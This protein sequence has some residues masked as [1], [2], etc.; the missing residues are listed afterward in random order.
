[1]HFKKLI[2]LT[3]SMLMSLTSMAMDQ[4]DLANFHKAESLLLAKN[5]K[6]YYQVK[7][8]LTKVPLYP[9]LQYQEISVDPD[10]FK[11][12]TIDAYLKQNAGSFWAS[13]LKQ[14]LANYY[15][16]QKKW[17]NFLY[18]YDN[19][20]GFNGKCYAVVAEYSVG[21]KG[22]AIN[23]FTHLW[24]S[25]A[26]LP[27][28]CDDF[29]SIWE[30][31]AHLSERQIRLKAYALA[32]SGRVKEAL[33]WIN[34]TSN[35]E[36][37]G[38]YALWLKTTQNPKKY[39]DDW[40][41]KFHQING[42]SSAAISVM[43]N[44]S[45]KDT[46]YAED[47][48][49]NFKQKH[50][51]DNKTINLINAEIAIDYARAHNK[52]AIKWLND[53]EDKYASSLL[54]QWR[55]RTAIYWSDYKSYL[56][57]YSKL[58]QSL[59][60]EEGWR[61]WQAKSYQA[62]KQNDKAKSILTA[63]A[64]NVSYY[65]FLAAD[66]L[67]L[68]YTLNNKSAKVDQKTLDDMASNQIVL[69]I[70]DLYQIKEYGLSYALWRFSR[71]GFTRAE[72]LAIAELAAQQQIYQ[73]S[74]SAYASA[75]GRD[76]LTGLYPLAF[77]SDVQKAGKEF[78]I[79]PEVIIS[80]MRQ[81]SAFRVH[82]VSSASATGLMQLLPTTAAFLA[83]KYRISYENDD[84]YKPNKVIMLGAANL[85]FM[86][87]LF[88]NNLIIGM[89]AYNAG[90]GNAVNWLPAQKLAA[91]QWIEIIPFGETRKYVK[92]ILRNLVIYNQAIL[93]NKKF[94]LQQVMQS[95]SQKDKT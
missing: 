32:S 64:K 45:A 12:E 57:W 7:A 8:K 56:G 51:L 59:K 87:Q 81:E 75:G 40:A 55:L 52:K 62:L 44:L 61:Y 9:F 28:T 20:L 80:M 67:G 36:L 70:F 71:H 38:F 91:D 84:L 65:G 10:L 16:K 85:N 31:S 4:T 76:N 6:D 90:Q 49:L 41:V 18:Y 24:L 54:W 3:S 13:Q 93:G 68:S 15:L 37:Q 29:E 35:K 60:S 74:T 86:D 88:N 73:I 69:Q 58:P 72:Q 43:A 33:K 48:W 22:K 53:V 83:K 79:S 26:N 82:G 92:N 39:M 5:Y 2:L 14:D 95:I 30:T 50:L 23:D 21:D 77:W 25:R 46:H 11:Q 78:D 66:D 19:N 47:F 1:M 89:A 42:F 34:K 63:L 17:Q 94:R 27:R